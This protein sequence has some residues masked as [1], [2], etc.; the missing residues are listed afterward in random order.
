VGAAIAI[1]T[2]VVLLAMGSGLLGWTTPLPERWMD[3]DALYRRDVEPFPSF[4]DFTPIA[5]DWPRDVTLARE[6][7]AGRLPGWNPLS[8]CGAPLWADQDGPFF[9]LK[10]PF[11]AY[12][13]LRT[14]R[15]FLALRLFAAGLGAYFLARYRGRRQVAAL[16]AAATFALSG[17]LIEAVPFGSFSPLC[18]LPWVLLAALTIADRHDSISAAAGAAAIGVSASGGHPPMIAMICA[19]FAVAL[20][21]QVASDRG[22]THR[23][24]ALGWGVAALLLGLLLAAPSLFPLAELARLSTSYK[25]R[26]VGET[27]WA[28]ALSVSRN[29]LPLAWFAPSLLAAV[30]PLIGTVH[31]AAAVLGVTTLALAV[32][33]VLRRGLDAPLACVLVFGIALATAPPGLGWV[34]DLPALHFVLPYYA[35]ALVA[36]PLTQAAGTAVEEFPSLA[37]RRAVC[38]GLAVAWIGLVSLVWVADVHSSLGASLLR[39]TWRE[40]VAAPAGM[41][42]LAWPPL[43][44]TVAVG[45]CAALRRTRFA[46]LSGGGLGVVAAAELLLLWPTWLQHPTSSV[47]DAEPSPAV[48]FLQQQLAGGT[49]RGMAIPPEVGLPMTP[50]QYG[51]RDLRGYSPLPVG[52]Y[53][54][55]VLTSGAAASRLVLQTIPVVPSPLIDRAAVRYIATSRG[56]SEAAPRLHDDPQLPLAYADD[57]VAI[58][59]NRAALARARIAHRALPVADADAAR[60][61]LESLA[62]RR[63]P[64]GERE[65]DTDVVV[66]PAAS[67]AV[68]P[69]LAAAQ[70]AETVHLIDDPDPDVVIADVDLDAPGLVVVAD[71]YYPGWSATVDGAPTPIFPADLLFRAVYAPA[72]RH[73]VELRYAPRSFTY[74][75]WA[76]LAAAIV[77]G[78]LVQGGRRARRRSR[79]SHAG[80]AADPD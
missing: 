58:Y 5:V 33:G 15:L 28:Y 50:L 30:R 13:S 7:H 4:S 6:L 44:A 59:E 70:R 75:G 71:T 56:G 9:P 35:W 52:R 54:Q 45:A 46:A 37:G 3:F 39:S 72:G 61:A 74:G 32:G 25:A 29:A 48:R 34:G 51:I 57:H 24:A 26:P 41:L 31:S 40:V 42:R 27:A 53:E 76:A 43:C 23:A 21:A 49:F 80:A 12:P 69:T 78:A 38:I 8:A 1:L 18:V 20:L 63:G 64:A 36:L 16:V 55:Y 19:A 79:T 65:R 22:S 60:R 73:R 62:Q 67:G 11:Y 77:C 14:Y 68:V 2:A 66:E 47:L 10:L 17:A